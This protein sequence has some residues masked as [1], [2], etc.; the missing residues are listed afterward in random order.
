VEGASDLDRARHF[1]EQA[2]A[3]MVA[4]RIAPT[5]HNF[6]VWYAHLSGAQP[7][8]S[9]AIEILDSNRVEFT[10]E[11]NLDLYEQLLGASREAEQIREA[12]ERISAAAGAVLSVLQKAGAGTEKYGEVLGQATEKIEGEPIDADRLQIIVE[13]IL[14]ETRRMVTQN[15]EIVGRL[16][17]SSQ[18]IDGLRK[19]IESARRETLV[20]ALTGVGNRRMFDMRLRECLKQTLEEGGSL[21]LLM[22]DID[23]FKR[24]NDT[25]GHQLGDLVLRLVAKALTDGIK[26]RDVA[27]R[28]GG[29]EFGILLP[30]TRLEDALKLADGLRASIGARRVIKRGEER[31][32]GHVTLSMGV[33]LYRPGEPP[34]QFVQRADAA[35]YTAKRRGRNRVVSEAEVEAGELMPAGRAKV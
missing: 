17:Q 25:F 16:A 15:Q 7:D 20:D 1:A 11:R 26:G 35:L 27:C 13:A 9:R 29:E 6:S 3:A 34:A 8:L 12:G 19:Q 22:A 32:L 31:D 30:K 33:S 23:H 21:C 2:L 5:P 10:P 18:E 24:F 14:D 28:Y 4:R